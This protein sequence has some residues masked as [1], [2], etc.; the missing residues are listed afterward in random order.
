M[1]KRRGKFFLLFLREKV[2]FSKHFEYNGTQK[3]ILS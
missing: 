1:E 2:D 3:Y